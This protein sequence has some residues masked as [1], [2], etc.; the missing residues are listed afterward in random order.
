MNFRVTMTLVVMCLV[1]VSAIAADFKMEAKLVSTYCTEYFGMVNIEFTNKSRD[2]ID[3]DN[4]RVSFGSPEID[5][6]VTLVTGDK[7]INWNDAITEK[8]ESDAFYARLFLGTLAAVGGV[9]AARNNNTKAGAVAIG[10]AG[11]LALS[12]IS[13]AS[14]RIQVAQLVPRTHLLAGNFSIP[15]GLSLSRWA[16]FNTKNNDGVPV[17]TH[18][19]IAAET[20]SGKVIAEKLELRWDTDKTCKW[21]AS[22]MPDH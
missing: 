11:A 2:W 22:I 19:S 7:L 14:D 4:L 21:Q 6:K 10:S 13:S 12:E 5:K 15:P 1:P 3:I 20:N 16:L 18:I 8:Q 17:I 9:V